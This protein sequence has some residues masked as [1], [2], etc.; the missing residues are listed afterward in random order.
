MSQPHEDADSQAGAG[1]L[2]PGPARQPER[3]ASLD[4][5]RGIAV[6]GILGANI[7]VFGQPFS[8]IPYPGAFLSPTGDPDGWLWIAQFVLIDGKMRGLFTI[9]F[10]AGLYLFMERARARGATNGL[11]ARR[12]SW[13]LLFGLIHFFLLWRGDIL[14]YYAL[15]AL[16]LLLCLRWSAATQLHTGLF[17]YI[18]GAI[19]Y[20]PL[21][22]F[23]WAVVDTSLGESEDFAEMRVEMQFAMDEILADDAVVSV[24][25]QEGD[26]AGLIAHKLEHYRY[27]LLENV[28]FSGFEIIPLMLIGMALYRM[29]FFAGAFNPGAMRRWGWLGLAVGAALHLALGLW[30]KAGG[31]TFYGTLAGAIGFSIIARLMMIL[32][33]AALLVLY[34]PRATGWL[35]QRISA[36]GRAAFTNYLGTSVLMLFVFQG[37]GLGLFGELS[38]PQLYGVAAGVC[39]VMLVWSKLWLDRYRYGPLEWLWRCLTYGKVLPISRL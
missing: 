20:A 21:A 1:A 29:G 32:G 24:L 9:L 17:G 10:G 12:L 13:L 5:L 22:W 38:R 6:M 27:E 3:I 14:A 31:F 26:F 16:P 33:L 28:V 2:P 34:T 30:V 36:A 11:Q 37:W 19:L 35:G 23:P 25:K 39:G 4:F 7:I 18:L 15:C 8:A